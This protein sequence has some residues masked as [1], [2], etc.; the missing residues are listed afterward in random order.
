ML[1]PI[2]SFQVVE[3]RIASVHIVRGPAVFTAILFDFFN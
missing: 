2:R 3:L 1:S